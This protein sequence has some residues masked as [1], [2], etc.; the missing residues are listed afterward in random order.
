MPFAP[1]SDANPSSTRA[2]RSCPPTAPA[3]TRAARDTRERSQSRWSPSRCCDVVD[4]VVEVDGVAALAPADDRHVVDAAHADREREEIRPLEREVRRVV[5]AEARAGDDD[6]AAAGVVVDERRDVPRSSARSRRGGARAPRAARRPRASS[7]RPRRRRSRPSPA[8]RRCSGASAPIMPESSQS[9]R[10]PSS[11]GNTSSGRPQWPYASRRAGPT[12]RSRRFTSTLAAAA[13]RGADAASRARRSSCA[14][15]GARRRAH[16]PAAALERVGQR[17]VVVEVLLG[18]A[19]RD[20]RRDARRESPPAVDLPDE[21]RDPREAR[22]SRTRTSR[23]AAGRSCPTGGTSAA[24]QARVAEVR[25]QPGERAE[26]RAEQHRRPVRRR[27]RA[28]RP[29]RGPPPARSRSARTRSTISLRLPGGG[30][31]RRAKLRHLAEVDEVVE[32]A[33]ERRVLRVLGTVV[34]DQQRQ[35][36]LRIRVRRRPEQRRDGRRA[37]ARSRAAARSASPVRSPRPRPTREARSRGTRSTLLSPNGPGARSGFAGS[38]STA[39]RPVR[40][41]SSSTYSSRSA[42]GPRKGEAPGVADAARTRRGEAA[43]ARGGARLPAKLRIGERELDRVLAE[44]VARLRS[45][46]HR[47]REYVERSATIVD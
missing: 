1:S 6:L 21:A 28:A 34:D 9:Q 47:A 27:L 36:P 19:A 18:G 3:R 7:R 44:R 13:R 2:P 29:A 39:R 14:R 26:A 8:R 35:R 16:V 15:R 10:L 46:A 41:V 4:R 12:S 32:Q 17:A 5:R 31:E 24:E 23:S 45:D 11:D 30:S 43:A 25:V 38:G 33:H 40:Y 22:R 42:G 20:R 37:G